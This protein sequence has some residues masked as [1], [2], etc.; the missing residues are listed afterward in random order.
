MPM[1]GCRPWTEVC[2]TVSRT[3]VNASAACTDHKTT[4]AVVTTSP[5]PSEQRSSLVFRE[6]WTGETFF[7]T[8]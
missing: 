1:P 3:C 4:T 7:A 8:C 5:S 6:Q 2:S